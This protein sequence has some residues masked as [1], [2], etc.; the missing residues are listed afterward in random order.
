MYLRFDEPEEIRMH[1]N[2]ASSKRVLDATTRCAP[3]LNGFLF[4]AAGNRIFVA[5]VSNHYALLACTARPVRWSPQRSAG[6]RLIDLYCVFF[7]DLAGYR[8]L[9]WNRDG[10]PERICGNALRALGEVFRRCGSSL[11]QCVHFE[12]F[13]AWVQSDGEDA[14]CHAP[15]E[16]FRISKRV[17]TGIAVDGGTPHLVH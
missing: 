8:A 9:F 17:G 2:D 11:P 14:T 12:G 3:R 13:D 5:E 6:G 1:G 10:T 7:W 16:A 15:E 4:D